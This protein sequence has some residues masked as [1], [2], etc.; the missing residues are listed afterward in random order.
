MLVLPNALVKVITLIE[1]LRFGEILN[2]E[3]PGSGNLQGGKTGR[4][5][6]ISLQSCGDRQGLAETHTHT[7]QPA[8]APIPRDWQPHPWG[9]RFQPCCDSLLWACRRRGGLSVLVLVSTLP[10]GP[11]CAFHGASP[12][13]CISILHPTISAWPMCDIW[14]DAV[15]CYPCRKCREWDS[16]PSAD[17]N[18]L[19][20]HP[21]L[22]H[23]LAILGGSLCE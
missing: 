11:L 4:A 12:P 13:L 2:K 1:T 9:S 20:S 7:S 8:A 14:G 17:P 18:P 23:T 21:L 16:R 3:P 6:Q 5:G 10:A 19:L 22:S 15:G